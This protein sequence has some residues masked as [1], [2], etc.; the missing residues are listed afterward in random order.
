MSLLEEVLRDSSEIR[1]MG[2]GSSRMRNTGVVPR[3][4][5]YKYV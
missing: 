5:I 3:V 1:Q 2:L 4:Y